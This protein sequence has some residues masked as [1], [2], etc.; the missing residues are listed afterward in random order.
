[1]I[2]RLDKL[3]VLIPDLET[4]DVIVIDNKKNAMNMKNAINIGRCNWT[5]P[6]KG[7]GSNESQ[8]PYD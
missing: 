5:K 6:Y 7:G 8:G 2:Q 1:M 4:G 3:F